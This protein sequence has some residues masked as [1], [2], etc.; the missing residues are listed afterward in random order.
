[1]KRLLFLLLFSC[2]GITQAQNF[3]LLSGIGSDKS[4][5][6]F[7]TAELYK[8]LE[9][10]T[11]YGFTD[12]KLNKNGYFDSYT[13]VFKY[14]NIGEKGYSFTGQI[15]AGLFTTEGTGIQINPVY[16]VGLSKA[17]NIGKWNLTLDVLYRMDY[18]LNLEGVKIGNG[19]Q[20][21]GTFLRDGNHFQ[22]LG[23][24]DLW[25]T[26]NSKAYNKNQNGLIVQ[27]ESQAWWKF[28]KRVYLGIEGR[29]S[30]FNDPNL[31]LYQ[32]SNYCMIGL[33]WNLEN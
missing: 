12:L 3:Q 6:N 24:C 14:W 27:F 4:S 30:N 26:E 15:N 28:S 16:L 20:L 10:G 2:F 25:Q 32:Y 13:E 23:Y 8:P 5:V 21:T 29:L 11:F 1:M 22:F 9:H 19:P 18:G 7:L 33:K 17:Q 31:G